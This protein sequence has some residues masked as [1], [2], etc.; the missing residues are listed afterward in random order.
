MKR[1]V[2]IP[3]RPDD[4]APSGAPKKVQ[5][6][7]AEELP[8]AQMGLFERPGDYLRRESRDATYAAPKTNTMAE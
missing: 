8:T 4:H 2:T 3:Q 7:G 1:R 5:M 6:L